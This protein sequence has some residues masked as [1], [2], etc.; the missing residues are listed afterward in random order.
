MGMRE[1]G[2][3][4]G[5]A[6]WGKPSSGVDTRECRAI[7]AAFSENFTAVENDKKR[8]NKLDIKITRVIRLRAIYAY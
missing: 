4:G 6:R 2:G 8:A 1:C 5:G 3:E 7:S